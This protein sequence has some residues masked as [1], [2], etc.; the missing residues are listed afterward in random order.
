MPS[1]KK[2]YK[3]GAI[4]AS[5][6]ELAL[7]V[8][9]DKEVLTI[10][11]DGK[12]VLSTTKEPGVQKVSVETMIQKSIQGQA[13]LEQLA[14][15]VV[16]KN[17]LI[18]PSKTELVVHVL[19]DLQVRAARAA[20]RPAAAVAGRAADKQLRVAQIQDA[21]LRT[22]N[23]DDLDD[24]VELLYE[25]S[26]EER[27]RG[28][29]L[30]AALFRR[31]DNIP[32]LLEHPSVLG[33][34][35][36]VLRDDFKRSIDLAI[37]VVSAMF[38]ISLWSNFHG[39][40][41]SNQ[42]G[43][44]VLDIID[45][46]LRRTEDRQVEDGVSPQM[47]AQK[48]A[49]QQMGIDDPRLTERER[50]L[51]AVVQKQDRLLYYALYFLLNLAQD[52]R[53][54][55][56]MRKRGIV[57]YLVRCL[58]R[59]NADLLIVVMMFLKKL[60]I[61]VENKDA[62]LRAG[63]VPELLRYVPVGNE[64]LLSVTLRLL[65]NLS[66]DAALRSGM[67]EEGIVPR[68]MQL[69]NQAS[70]HALV[71]GLLYHLS[72]DDQAKREAASTGAIKT[73]RS[74]LLQV[75]D[76]RQTPELIALMVNL[77]QD[78]QCAEKL[79]E[80]GGLRQLMQQALETGD[81]LLFKVLRNVSQNNSVN[82]RKQFL[83]YVGTL[84][85]MV[86]ADVTSNVLVEVL[87]MLGNVGS[88]PGVD[89]AKILREHDLLRF[90]AAAVR[91]DMV[92]DDILLEVVVFLGALCS[93]TTAPMIVEAGLIPALMDLITE[94]K[95]DDEFVLQIAFAFHKLL[96]FADTRSVLLQQGEVVPYLVDLLFDRNRHVR[97]VAG[98]AVDTIVDSDESWAVRI[99]HIKFEH[100]N[101]AWIQRAHDA[102][103]VRMMRSAANSVG[104]ES[105]DEDAYG[106]VMLPGG[107]GEAIM[108]V[109]GLV[110]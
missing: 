43:V 101:A 45:L 80:G 2:K 15:L 14:A 69:L 84:V 1:T 103:A 76:L 77:S 40:L 16:E 38:A 83:P 73:L 105:G 5:P 42:V 46:E 37:N 59:S 35:T 24:Y 51:L 62:M 72:M 55:N 20:G 12:T 26:L 31:V 57:E 106:M 67:V 68:C 56:K 79:C 93:D 108:D 9:Y 4:E 95:H 44:L 78:A 48:V 100:Y 22:A 82:I 92:E 47:V 104:D 23:I 91:P 41:L 25:D 3:P 97:E 19:A 10:A 74:F 18:H 33:A 61:F 58:D 94:R 32:D 86:K 13:K 54:E 96:L 71:M 70:L 39:L 7:L 102:G 98:K 88:L 65:H 107:T 75:K 8:H 81:D 28:T 21:A 63:A 89:F 52:A 64:E 60:S 6:T 109:S 53:V 110:M 29:A 34:L 90:L 30:V 36:R 27:L 87:G 50:K 99:R 49:E 17:K 85:G 66:F 11:D